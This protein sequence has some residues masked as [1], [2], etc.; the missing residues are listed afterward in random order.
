[1]DPPA[2][3]ATV[4]ELA[5][6]SVAQCETA[7]TAEAAMTGMHN[8]LKSFIMLAETMTQYFMTGAYQMGK[9]K[10]KILV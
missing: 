4:L 5:K 1:M 3:V 6:A 2:A 9:K 10:T 8:S 7:G